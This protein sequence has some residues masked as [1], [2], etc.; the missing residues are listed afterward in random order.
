MLTYVDV[1]L[2]VLALLVVH[3]IFK[4]S[5]RLKLPLPPGPKG[6]PLIGNAHQIPT[7]FGWQRYHEWCKEYNTDVLYINVAG[8]DIVVLDSSKAATDLLESRS[9]LYSGRPRMPMLNELM[10]WNFNLGGMD[11][12]PYWHVK[13]SLT[14]HLDPHLVFSRRKHRKLTHHSFHPVAAKQFRPLITKANNRLLEKFLDDPDPHK[15][16]PHIRYMAGETVLSIAYGIEIQKDNDPYIEAAVEAVQPVIIAAIPGAFLVDAIPLLKY[17]PEWFPGA[18]F[19][20][21]AREWRVLARRVVEL[22]Y[23]EAKKTFDAGT[24]THS[25][26][27]ESLARI[28]DGQKDGAFAED[29]IQNVAG[30][31][32]AAGSETACIFKFMRAQAELDAVVKPGYLPDFHDQ[33]SLPYITAIA[34]ETLRWQSVFPIAIPHLLNSEDEYRGY[35]LPEGAIIIPNAWAMLHDEGVY[36]DPFEFKPDRFINPETGQLDFTRA[37]DPGH[38]CWGFGRRICPARYMAFDSIWLAI[39][40]LVYVFDL[41]K[42]KVKRRNA[43]GEEV[44]EVV[45]LSH[46]YVSGLAMM[47]KPFECVIK[48]RSQDKAELVRSYAAQDQTL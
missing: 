34:K 32:Y 4:R 19:R 24:N 38:A 41:E 42:A 39:A 30:T 9:S 23:A 1:A 26:V 25:I 16:M 31:L 44:E 29:V 7:S 47:P 37:R 36:E 15:I 40:S 10:G 21:K 27:S 12:G 6:L 8:T 5:K 11:Y 43:N 35:R 22:P 13:V 17:V 28:R 48:P 3:S 2:T 46:E 45:E 18:S 14:A 33:S 20:R